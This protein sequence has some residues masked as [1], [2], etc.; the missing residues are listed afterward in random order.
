[1]KLLHSPNPCLRSAARQRGFTLVELIMVI[2]ILG[3]ISAVVAVFIAKPV[4]G[5]V[6]SVNRSELTDQADVALRRLARDVRLALPNSLR[7][8][9]SANATVA[10]CA[11]GTDCTLE[12]ILTKT[13][14]RYR[15][16]ADGSAFA[17]ANFLSF[18][19]A[20]PSFDVLGTWP[21][22]PPIAASDYIVVYNL[23]PGYAPADAYTATGNRVQ[24]ASGWAGATA[25]VPLTAATQS[26]FSTQTPSLP[27]PGA[28][29]QV[30]DANDMVVRYRCSAAA[31]L[32]RF[33]GCSFT[34]TA[35][36]ARSASIAAD[37][38][39]VPVT[40]ASCEVEYDANAT[41]RNGLLTLNLALTRSGET[42]TLFQQIHV[43]NSP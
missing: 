27:S 14:G 42:V 38:S 2:V 13:G 28:R 3:I 29:F 12:L 16:A 26:V 4:Q 31:G 34:A 41:G 40:T 22:N 17:G 10:S 19:A 9:N 23:G 5:Y 6:D 30:V 15:D 43:N 32:V 21:L 20:T 7:L 8:K 36:C 18:N 37:P 33:A 25:T 35:T 39:A 11:A 1:M 24:V